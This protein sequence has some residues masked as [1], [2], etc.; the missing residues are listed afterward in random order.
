MQVIDFHNIQ[1]QAS[2]TFLPKYWFEFIESF[3]MYISET[4]NKRTLKAS[5]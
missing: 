5:I 4:D 1:Y 2:L 3:N